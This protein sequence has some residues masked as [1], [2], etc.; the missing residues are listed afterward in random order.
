MKVTFEQFIEL[1]RQLTATK[2][3][4]NETKAI[5]TEI[6]SKTPKPLNWS[7]FNEL[8]LLCNKD[9]VSKDFF[10]FFF[11]ERT[12]RKQAGLSTIDANAL[13]KGIDDFRKLAMLAFGNFKFAYRK[14]SKS[15]LAD[16]E[17]DLAAFLK[18]PGAI[19]QELSHRPK[20][21]QGIYPIAKEQ[22]P[23]IG[24]ITSKYIDIEWKIAYFLKKHLD[25]EA[26]PK[27]ENYIK[28]KLE[29]NV[30]KTWIQ[31]KIEKERTKE[32]IIVKPEHLMSIINGMQKCILLFEEHNPEKSFIALRKYANQSLEKLEKLKTEVI[33][34]HKR[35][36]NNTE[37]YLTWDYLDV[38][39]ATSMREKWEYYTFQDF[40][41]SVFGHSKLRDLQLRYFD[42]TQ[43]FD[44]NRVNKGLTEGLMLK[45]AKCTIYSIQ[46]SDTLGKDSELAT[47][48]AQG[49][50][51][52]AY[53]P[54]I[55][56]RKKHSEFLLEWASSS[57]V[58]L[59]EK[60][61]TLLPIFDEA[62]V[63]D[64]C[65]KSLGISDPKK[66]KGFL[67]DCSDKI[68]VHLSRKAWVSIDTV[69][70][71]DSELITANKKVFTKLCHCLAIADQLFYNKRAGTLRNIHPL[72]IQVNLANG[73]ANGV[74]VVRSVEDCVQLL[75]NIITNQMDLKLVHDSNN[76]YTILEEQI[77][78]SIFRVVTDK[79]SLTNSFWNF[80]LLEE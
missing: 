78:K 76:G 29:T 63:I 13:Q 55:I 67:R 7:Q 46:E 42:P 38:Y 32:G 52:I 12:G 31:K 62:E 77:S 60:I 66:L 35:G 15:T 56:D 5:L 6:F 69:W 58:F 11:L 25:E 49:K 47:T 23:H 74:L 64:E 57:V 43:S 18:K 17:K 2:V 14:L 4:C 68:A 59:R 27:I 65:S 21:V 79:E 22:T 36:K 39:F 54:E 40:E 16:I 48:L 28:K 3:N 26:T 10:D 70:A 72:G 34:V 71:Q 45:R 37:I 1:L 41:K 51:V 20:K 33:Q 53:V 75:Y 30:L 80:Y 44:D 19:I 8:L 9:R 50:P 61:R 73:V 24:Y